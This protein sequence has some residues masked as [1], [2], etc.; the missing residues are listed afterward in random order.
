MPRRTLRN[1]RGQAV[2]EFAV[3]LPVL[4]LVLLAIY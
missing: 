3:I 2:T 4:L 1:Q